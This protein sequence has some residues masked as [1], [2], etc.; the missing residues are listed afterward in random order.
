MPQILIFCLVALFSLGLI[1]DLDA[2][3]A[4]RLRSAAIGWIYAF[5]FLRLPAW[6]SLSLRVRVHVRR[7]LFQK[8]QSQIRIRLD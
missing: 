1:L 2:S 6:L 7:T 8:M 5:Y 4:T 3:G